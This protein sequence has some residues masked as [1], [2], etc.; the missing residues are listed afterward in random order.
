MLSIDDLSVTF[1]TPQGDLEAVRHASL[2]VGQ[3]ETVAL[4]GESGS[5]KSVTALSVLG[6]LPYPRARHPSGSIRF[7][8]R[9]L[10]GA[11]DV[12]LRQVRGNRISMIFQEPMLAL[13]PLH[14]VLKQVTETLTLH[15]GMTPKQARNRTL[16][17][18]QLVRMQEPEQKLLAYPHQ[19]SGGQRQR[20]MI[21]MAL[22][23]EPDLLIADEPTTAVDVTI[24]AQILNLLA[25]LQ[26]QLSMSILLITHDLDVVQ[27]TINRSYVMQSGTIVEHG[28]TKQLFLAPTNSYTRQLIESEPSGAPNPVEPSASTVLRGEHLRVW[29]PVQKGV[30]RRTVDQIK[31]VD[32]VTLTIR[33]G[34]TIGIVG[35]SGSGKTTL[36]LALARLVS[37]RGAIVFDNASIQGLKSRELKPLRRNLQIVF[38]DPYGSLSPRLS[39]GQIIEEGLVAHGIG[40]EEE[41]T[42]LLIDALT[43]VGLDPESRHRYPHEFSGGQRQRIALARAMILKPRL[44]ILDEP[45]SALDRTVQAQ[46]ID[47]LRQLQRQKNL[48]YLFISHDLKVIRALSDEIIVLHKGRVVEQG[49]AEKIFNH[50]HDPYTQALISAAY[51][52]EASEDSTMAQ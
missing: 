23:N 28:E 38:Q 7:H 30:L 13:N 21:A 9:E 22:A 48:A 14:T 10:L 26:Q 19:L 2:Q 51:N 40:T 45:T 33:A 32:D 50:P 11:G 47:L 1:S 17:L 24:Q 25:E 52:L 36:A 29:F 4:V 3:G 31:A 5:G 37:S 20:V 41:R 42:Q 44:I 49:N 43:E 34:Q 18:L 27:K 16:E 12:V 46:I 35:E 6:L 15:K 39:V 8:D